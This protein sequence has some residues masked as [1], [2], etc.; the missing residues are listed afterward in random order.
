M[1]QGAGWVSLGFSCTNK[2][3]TSVAPVSSAA[4]AVRVLIFPVALRARPL[5][6]GD[7]PRYDARVNTLETVKARR[8]IRE[9]SDRDVTREEVE[10]LLDAAVAAPNHRLT[11]P[12]RFYVLGP[13]ARRAYGMALGVRK[14]KRVE[15]PAAAD[16]VR[17][18]VAQ[19]HAQLP[20]MIAVAV[21]QDANPEIRDED[22]AATMMAVQNI[23][24]AAVELGLGTHI[25][26]GGIM[27]DP[28]ARVAVGV[29]DGERIVA[30]LNVGK[31]AATPAVKERRPAASLTTWVP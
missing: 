27:D 17:L 1:R 18:K 31:P 16:A 24:L 2:D 22:H 15:D 20:L 25:K 14:A 26:T 11:Q 19:E 6:P 29:P 13:E 9:F 12:W 30:V 21:V 8:S 23:S 7:A 28:A 5:A 10:T 4:S 3:T